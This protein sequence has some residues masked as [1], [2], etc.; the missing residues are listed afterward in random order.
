MA[1]EHHFLYLIFLPWTKEGKAFRGKE[2][3]VCPKVERRKGK[4]DWIKDGIECI[5]IIILMMFVAVALATIGIYNWM[6][7]QLSSKEN[8]AK[9]RER[10]IGS[11]LLSI[12]GREG[13]FY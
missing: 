4:V 3:K 1:S 7:R 2:G 5:T 9:F 12:L 8:R 10:S 13:D 11:A 6:M